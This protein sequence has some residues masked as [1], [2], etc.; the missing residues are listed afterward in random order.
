MR[1]LYDVLKSNPDF[2]KVSSVARGGK[3]YAV[4]G[5]SAVHKA[6]MIYALCCETDSRAFCVASNEQEAATLCA[7]LCNMGL[8]AFVYPYRD[9][10]FRDIAGKSREYEHQRMSVLLR[11]MSGDCDCVIACADAAAQY[12]IP[13]SCLA[14]AT[15][16]LRAGQEVSLEKCV[17]A[18]VL[19]GYERCDQIEGVGQFSL[20]GGILDFYPPDSEAP[21]RA[22]FW[23]DEID[24]L[25]YF[26]SE[27]QRRGEVV[28]EITLSP[29]A[30]VFISDREGL[31]AL[32]EKKASSL[33]AE[34]SVKA[35][36]ILRNEA[37]SIRKGLHLANLDKY[38]SLIYPEKASLFDYIDDSF[39]CFLCEESAVKD[40]MA[41]VEFRFKED[42]LDYFEEG[43]LCRGLDKFSLTYKE[44][45]EELTIRGVGYLDNFTAGSH[46]LPLSA[47]VNIT[48]KSL[49]FVAGTVSELCEE[50][51]PVDKKKSTI[52]ILAGTKK[53]AQNLF[54]SLLDKGYKTAL[55]STH[56][57]LERG[58]IYITEGTLSSGLEYTGENFY[59]YA[60]GKREGIKEQKKR[61]TPK[62]GQEIYSLSDLSQGDYVVHT[63]HGIGIFE[64][65]TKIDTHG[66]VKDYIKIAYAKSDVLYVPVTQLDLVAK[67]IGPRENSMVKLSRLGGAE[68]QKA[69]SRVKAAVKDMAKELIA[70]YSARM[71]APGY[72]FAPDSEWQ[73]DFEAK[74]EYEETE[75]QLRCTDE[76]KHDMERT[77][78][79]DRL[80]CGDVGFG[81]TEVAL[82]AAFKCITDSKQCALLCPTTILA[83]QHYQTVLK[84]FEGYPIRVELLS[85]FRKPKEQEKI[86]EM[87]R[88][89]EIDMVVGTHRLVQKD[90]D[91]RD[92]GLVIIDEEQRF[93]VAHKERFK[94]LCKNVDV[95]TLSATPIPR[96]LNMALSGIRDLSVLEEAPSNRYPVQT[97]VLEYDGGVV[98]EAIRKELRR[99]GQVFYL[100]NKV[101]DIETKA[102]YIQQVIPEARVGI[103]HGKMSEQELSA[104]WREMLEQNINVLVCTTIIETGVDL[105]NAN[106][107]II[108]DAHKFG[109][110][111]LH[112]IRGRVGRSTRR[113]W[114]Y[115]TFPRGYNLSDISQKR[116]NAIREFT[117]FGSGMK[118]AMRDLELRGAGSVLGANQHGHMEDVGY[119]M[120]LKILDTAVKEELGEIPEDREEKDCLVDVAV[121]AHIP[122]SYIESLNLR[123]DVYKLIADV[124]TQEDASDVLDELIDRFGD[125]PKSVMGLIDV[126]LIRNRAAQLGIYEIKQN[127]TTLLLYMNDVKNQ[128]LISLVAKAKG[129]ALLSA[130]KKPYIALRAVAKAE[131]L[132]ALKAFFG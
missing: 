46:T 131:P 53:G 6:N 75:D 17:G 39:L 48:A 44:I 9:F 16:Y 85:R 126:A 114:A 45:C 73:R 121:V 56:S 115:L 37:E 76:I 62:N 96:T 81:K 94:E 79:M 117:E 3:P 119:D 64:G 33:R 71:N 65:V 106:T 104:V 124:R 132:S 12:T 5:L 129:K 86:L 67:Y 8:R 29:S 30:E 59:L 47:L 125:V 13:P 60:Q 89:G 11:I 109:L 2:A 69:K 42:V 23:G 41:N 52:V 118:I 57:Q 93:G 28:D 100:H 78:P 49:P 25:N 120:Y 99:G 14:D 36:E 32:I 113:A 20:R 68:W 88:R 98:H 61:K 108:E 40:R 97:Y 35:K 123:L 58:T 21:I 130:G 92:L 4:S 80:L 18:L 87:L 26:D 10:T 55:V 51:E 95:L 66:I 82:R 127:D 116:L 101:E 112:Q 22:E 54:E 15:L 102:A 38:I 50:L 103:G 110:S 7:D 111:Q 19:L 34:K 107:L 91:F 70:L 122:E 27:T 43:V 63:T 31:A 105:P 24:S 74:F 77:A 83:W 1:F 72:A 84:R 90:V 128:E